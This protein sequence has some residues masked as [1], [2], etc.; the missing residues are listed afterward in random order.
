MT[1]S[2]A[3]AW[4]TPH[5]ALL[6]AQLLQLP[7]P[8]RSLSACTLALHLQPVLLPA[9]GPLIHISPCPGSPHQL[10]AVAQDGAAYVL[11]AHVADPIPC[12]LAGSAS[13]AVSKESN[14]AQPGSGGSASCTTGLLAALA[15]HRGAEAAGSGGGG[16]AALGRAGA[17]GG[18]GGGGRRRLALQLQLR[19][20]MRAVVGLGGHEQLLGA[21][22]AAQWTAFNRAV[23]VRC[24]LRA[25]TICMPCV[26][27]RLRGQRA[28]AACAALYLEGM[29]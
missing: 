7:Q 8:P 2:G 5:G 20:L 24:V 28:L 13:A 17:G 19:Q 29:A 4:V 25:T 12:G 3:L 18:G 10:L 14:K 27:C 26:P 9:P 15:G 16:N 11:P 21:A 1:P 22:A 23:Q 6:A